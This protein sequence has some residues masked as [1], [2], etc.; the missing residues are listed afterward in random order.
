MRPI[1]LWCVTLT[2]DTFE[3]FESDLPDRL[4]QITEEIYQD[5]CAFVQKCYDEQG[6]LK[7]QLPEKAKYTLRLIF[8]EVAYRQFL[9][10]QQPPNQ[11]PL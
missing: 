9:I 5:D 6:Y 7:G 4:I 1:N 2:L 8:R 11:E 10:R 3:I